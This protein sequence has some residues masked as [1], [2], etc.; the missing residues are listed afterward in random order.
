MEVLRG[1]REG[2]LRGLDLGLKAY[3]GELEPKHEQYTFQ[4]ILKTL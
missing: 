3:R 4:V 2:Q 1:N